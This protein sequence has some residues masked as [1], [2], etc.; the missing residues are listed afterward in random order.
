MKKNK[1]SIVMNCFNGEEY[2]EQ[3]LKSILHQTYK[4]WE[5]IFMDN[6]SDDKSKEI[7]KKIK[8]I[9]IKYFK[10]KRKINL[11]L[12]RKKALE[13]AKGEYIAFL[14]TDDLWEKNK[15][16]RQL[17]YFKDPKIGFV[18]SNT[19]FFNNKKNKI[20][21][22]KNRRFNKNVFYDLL[23]DYFISFDTVMIKK[24]YLN[25]LSHKFDK[26]FN[27]I[28]DMDL[29]IR[30]SRICEM[31]YAPFVLSKWR[32]RSNS[33]S[34]NNLKDILFEKEIFIKKIEKKNKRNHLF[35]ES[36]KIFDD[37]LLRQKILFLIS[38]KLFFKSLGLAKNLKLNIKNLIVIFLIFL[39]FK[40]LIFNNFLN[41]KYD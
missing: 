30:L 7:V 19:L 33:Y 32:M 6:C 24:K 15:L 41:I 9:R 26:R 22:D 4:N 23:K 36:K 1:V 17:Q 40:K 27:I 34:Y 29:L 25:K 18:I 10:T 2:L 8:D 28:H 39:P 37:T 38:K 11:G 35:L 31:G 5:L 21:Y 14:D 20:F 12:A 3:S 16:K 13:K